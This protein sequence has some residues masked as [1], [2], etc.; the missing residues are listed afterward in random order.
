MNHLQKLGGIA[1]LLAALI[2]IAAFI[3]YGAILEYPANPDTTKSLAFLSEN[4]RILSMTSFI[5]YVLFG[6]FL[7]ILV[8]ALY[9]RFK[10]KAELISQGATIFGIVWVTLVIAAGMIETIGLPAIN[11]LAVNDPEQ[12]LTIWKTITLI[13]AG[14]GGGNEIVGGLWVLLLSIAGLKN[15]CFPKTLNYLGIFVGLIGILTTYPAEVLTEIFGLSQIVWFIW[16]GI[17]MQKNK[18]LLSNR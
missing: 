15:A 3:V 12:A 9:K 5:T 4:E 17:T 13:T 14:I 6:L 2:Y 11:K 16:I 7:S 1:A 10:E 8:L 18:L